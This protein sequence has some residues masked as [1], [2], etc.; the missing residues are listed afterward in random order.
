VVVP[1]TIYVMLAGAQVLDVAPQTPSGDGS[2][3]RRVD[4]S[5]AETLFHDG[6][7]AYDAHAY[8]RAL[9]FFEAAYALSPLPEI[10]FDIA[11][12]YR[13]LGACQQAVEHFDM[14]LSAVS[15]DDPLAARARSRRQ[16]LLPCARPDRPAA[17][18]EQ[19]A[20]AP[21]PLAHHLE[22]DAPMV[23]AHPV[24]VLSSPPQA[25][26]GRRAIARAGCT[27]GIGATLAAGLA[28][29]IFDLQAHSTQQ[30]VALTTTWDAAA[31]RA[32]ERGRTL[33]EV[34]TG[35]L[36]SAAILAVGT[37]AVCWTG[38]SGRSAE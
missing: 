33:A 25:A 18:S 13:A 35:L 15:A 31:E 14:F 36:I 11:Q 28:G 4:Q 6:L 26:G 30:T 17:K 27:A 32:D 9:T 16:E 20:E 21:A 34:G 1:L 3:E 12:S 19:V 7:K 24:S 2:A 38:W 23:S 37:A 8:P 29:G 5:T 10:Q 22:L